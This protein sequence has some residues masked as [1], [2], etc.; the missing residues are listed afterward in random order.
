MTRQRLS[1]KSRLRCVLLGEFSLLQG[2][3]ELWLQAG[4]EIVAVGSSDPSL[5]KW[6]TEIG[7]RPVEFLAQDLRGQLCDL[8]FDYLFSITNLKVLRKEV[9]DLATESAINFHDG[10][11][12]QYAGLNVPCWA[13]INGEQ[14]HG[15]TWHC[16]TADV[17]RGDLLVQE[18]FE[19]DA[20]DT[21]F[22]V[23]AK[24]YEAGLE[25]FSRLVDQLASGRTKPVSQG[26]NVHYF[27]L[28]D[29]PRAQG[30][31]DLKEPVGTLSRLPRALDFGRYFNPMGLPK[32]WFGHQAVVVG[33]ARDTG[34]AT[35]A[36]PGTIVAVGPSE[37]SRVSS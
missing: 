28:R 27:G 15:I 4:H 19:I 29:R 7:A 6:A 37:V 12:P 3:G 2:C 36:E 25:S 9:L 11:L 33:R 10:L 31:L 17:D 23:N 32:L 35:E 14:E 5:R 22:V 26:P 34:E 8:P 30:I 24:C 20:D 21:A 16:M 18:R 1:A 13:I